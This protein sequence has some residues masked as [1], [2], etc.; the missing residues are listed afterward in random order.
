MRSIDGK[1]NPALEKLLTFIKGD[2]LQNAP[3]AV[4]VWQYPEGREYYR[5]LIK[6]NTG[7]ELSPE[8]INKIGLEQIEK[9]KRELEKIKDSVGFKGTPAEFRLFLKTDP[10]FF[11]KT[12]QEIEDR[13]NGF[14][15]GMSQKID[16][17]FFKKPKAPYAV[18]RLPLELEGGM[19]FGQYLAPTAA[20]PRG[21]YYFNG[22]Q[23]NER[24]LLMAEGL[25]YHELIPGHH[26]QISLQQ[27]NKDLPDFQR[28]STENAYTEGW[29]EYA[30]WLGR[31]MGLFQD[32]YSLC[33]KFMMDM[34]IS[35]RLVV[36]SGMNFFEWPRSR[37]VGFMKENLIESA[38]QINSETLRYSVDI[39]GQALGYKLGSL[40]M[41]ELR[42]KAQK[43]LGK[44][45]DLRKFHE[46]VLANGAIPLSI[47]ERHIDWFIEK[48]LAASKD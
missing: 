18:K 16:D 47:L 46:A 43:A 39:P 31:E 28:E 11:P 27:E 37:A 41:F 3:G 26:F 34:F 5:Y 32:P 29:A 10:R 19:T 20:E 44:R 23:P 21:I 14:V 2:Y 33:G 30:S 1:I 13:L 25:I 42:D 17:Y 40:K 6:A 15:K 7:L 35:T 36:D 38:T 22:S 48:E 45:F 12:P 8:E 9:D 24:S 4:G